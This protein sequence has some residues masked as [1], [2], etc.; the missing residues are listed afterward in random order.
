M[1]KKKFFAFAFLFRLLLA[2]TVRR[3]CFSFSIS[4]IEKQRRTQ[5]TLAKLCLFGMYKNTRCR[6][7]KSTPQRAA[8]K[9]PFS[10]SH[11]LCSVSFRRLPQHFPVACIFPPPAGIGEYIIS[12]F[13][14]E[15]IVVHTTQRAGVRLVFQ[16]ELV[17]YCRAPL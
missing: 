4:P 6:K 17:L 14:A 3:G 12:H 10:T 13:L 16:G 5:E 8:Q 9:F 7:W 1:E 11:S 15:Q 2:H